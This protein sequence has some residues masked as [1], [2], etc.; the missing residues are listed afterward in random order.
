V[1]PRVDDPVV[2][3]ALAAVDAALLPPVVR[4][5]LVGDHLADPIGHEREVG[6][7]LVREEV[8]MVRRRARDLGAQGDGAAGRSR[9]R[10]QLGFPNAQPRA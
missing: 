6:G 10:Q 9:A 4:L 8:D 3:N 1:D 7:G 5:G 2:P